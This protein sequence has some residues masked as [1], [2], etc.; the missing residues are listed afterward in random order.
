MVRGYALGGDIKAH[1]T[2][3]LMEFELRAIDQNGRCAYPIR[4]AQV[5]WL[6]RSAEFA[7][8]RIRYGIGSAEHKRVLG[9]IV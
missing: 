1:S 6:R 7:G 4:L 3:F 5:S 2:R 8:A 9:Q